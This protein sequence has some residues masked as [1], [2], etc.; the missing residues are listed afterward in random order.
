V[1][2]QPI[3][4]PGFHLLLGPARTALG[5]SAYLYQAD[6]VPPYA[7]I[8]AGAAKLPDDRIG[9]TVADP[10][11]PPDRLVLYPDT[12]SVQPP[13]IGNQIP[14]RS[15]LRAEIG[16]WRPGRI[17]ISV[18]GTSAAPEYLV[19]S[20]NW[21]RDWTALVDG[22][23]APVLRGQGSLL[24]VALPPGTREV[25][26][27]YD[28]PSYRRGRLLSLASAMGVLFLLGWPLGRRGKRAD[29]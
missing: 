13:P 3:T 26:F 4:L 29:G 23:T 28:S 2:N 8:V 22:K 12:A 27:A 18:S 10:R 25:V 14:A 21:Y 6:T 7:R 17:R 11:F 1:A 5:D 19:V 9:A 15:A 24:S 16:E 20:E